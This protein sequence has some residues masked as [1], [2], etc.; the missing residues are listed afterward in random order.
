M[1]STRKRLAT[2]IKEQRE[3]KGLTL[4]S[5][6]ALAQ[7]AP[8][9]LSRWE[10]GSCTPCVPELESLLH[11]LQVEPEDLQ[12]IVASLDVPRAAIAART[13]LAIERC[14]PSGGTLL[15]ALRNRA[16]LSLSD[17]ATKLNVAVST[18]SRWESAASHPSSALLHKLFDLLDAS[19][20][21][22]LCVTE[23]GVAKLKAERGSFEEDRFLKELEDLESSLP[24]RHGTELRL[25]QLQSILWWSAEPAS[26]GLLRRAH[27]SYARFLNASGRFVEAAVEAEAALPKVATAGDWVAIEALR[28]LAKADVYRSNPPRPHFG[29]LTLQRAMD[30]AQEDSTRQAIEADMTIY[31]EIAV[32]RV[33]KMAP[34]KNA[35]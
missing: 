14:A 6:A 33:A 7:I 28:A 2:L 4:R 9:T 3:R 5:A 31:R 16:G 34:I 11:T 30:L 19:E 23:S 13:K 26:T 15:R 1:C 32:Q 21:E 27:L 18:V 29:L 20:E 22:R 24:F 12:K 25:L 17:L 8:S 35:N 10:S